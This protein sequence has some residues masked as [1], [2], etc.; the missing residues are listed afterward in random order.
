MINFN[1]SV[2]ENHSYCVTAIND[3]HA[4]VIDEKTNKIIKT[5]KS[6]LFDKVL[7]ANLDNLEKISN[8]PQFS[9]EKK[10]KYKGKILYLKNMI[11]QNDK[12]MKRYQ[13]DINIMSYNNKDMIK[14]TWKY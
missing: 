5:D 4:S 10:N 7:G 8:N 11:F 12:F 14:N 1:K 3:K 9:Y 6:D 2:P 13:N